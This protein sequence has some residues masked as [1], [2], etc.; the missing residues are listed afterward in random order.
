MRGHLYRYFRRPRGVQV[1]LKLQNLLLWQSSPCMKPN[2]E[3][4]Q[5]WKFTLVRTPVS[6]P[7]RCTPWHKRPLW[8]GTQGAYSWRI[9]RCSAGCSLCSPSAATRQKHS[10]PCTFRSAHRCGSWIDGSQPL[11][12]LA[13]TARTP[14]HPSNKTVRPQT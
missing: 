11:A 2:Q 9:P 5:I 8:P 12:G 6:Y 13:C 10:I 7:E 14:G 3:V 4:P 1:A